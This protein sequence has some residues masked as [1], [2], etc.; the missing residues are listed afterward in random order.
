M[1]NPTLDTLRQELA[2]LA[3][4][5]Q[6]D[7]AAAE[8]TEQLQLAK[9]QHLGK[10]ARLA[11]IKQSLGSLPKELRPDAGQLSNAANQAVKS[12]LETR[13]GELASQEQASRLQAERSD[14]TEVL[15]E[16]SVGHLHIITQTRRALEEV[17]CG[18]GYQVAEG[19]EIETDWHNFGALNFPDGHPPVTCTTP[20]MLTGA[21][22]S[23]PC[24]APTPRPC[25]CAPCWPSRRR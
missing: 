9:T 24:C 17:F 23:R 10:S 13:Q 11:A 8:S 21:N 22:R 12:A 19:P 1:N 16:V 4:A 7:F 14:L 3:E 18:M 20:C 2:E 15:G 25:R 6:Q 5:A